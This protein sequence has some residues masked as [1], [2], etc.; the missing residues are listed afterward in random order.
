MTRILLRDDSCAGI[1][2]AVQE[3]LGNEVYRNAAAEGSADFRACSGAAGAAKFIE[4]APHASG[5]MDM[6]KELN[7]VNA[8]CGL[9]YWLFVAAVI[10]LSGFLAGWQYAL[11]VGVVVKLF[12]NTCG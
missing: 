4:D 5:G 8:K 10:L 11:I 6:I 12:C 2:A 7:R 3:I 9:F 1:R